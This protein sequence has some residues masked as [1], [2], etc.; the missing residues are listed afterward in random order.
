MTVNLDQTVASSGNT[1][2]KHSKNVLVLQAASA[3]AIA[4]RRLCRLSTTFQCIFI[5][6]LGLFQHIIWILRT[7]SELHVVLSIKRLFR[8]R[9][10]ARVERGHSPTSYA[11]FNTE[12]PVDARPRKPLPRSSAIASA[13]PSSPSPGHTTSR[14]QP[15]RPRAQHRYRETLSCRPW[16]DVAHSSDPANSS[17][18]LT[19]SPTQLDAPH[20]RRLGPPQQ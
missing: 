19:R 12:L 13:T 3:A 14:C 11:Q 9:A 1:P 6:I 7:W 4:N 20:S 10:Q 15:P 8:P 16:A 5:R 17:T 2:A 18:S